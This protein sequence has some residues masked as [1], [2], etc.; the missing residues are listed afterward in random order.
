MRSCWKHWSTE[1]ANIGPHRFGHGRYRAHMYLVSHPSCLI[2]SASTL[3]Q[4]STLVE[5]DEV[6]SCGK[7]GAEFWSESGWCC[8]LIGSERFLCRPITE[9]C[10]WCCVA[11]N[12]RSA[13]GAL[14]DA[15]RTPNF[16]RTTNGLPTVING[17]SN[18]PPTDLKRI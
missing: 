11:G 17:S 8:M 3:F 10:R 5:L 1:E 2:T 14:T 7:L 9:L 6:L 13:I 4:F 16:Q 18:G 15:K 12:C